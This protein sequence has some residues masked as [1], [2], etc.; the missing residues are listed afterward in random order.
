[1]K[2]VAGLIG[3]HRWIP[4]LVWT[5][6]IIGLSSIPDLDIGSRRFPGCD[7]VAHFIEYSVLGIT[8]RYW[9]GRTKK[10]LVPGGLCFAALDELHQRYVPGREAS[11]WDFLADASGLIFG[12]LISRRF[13]RKGDD[14]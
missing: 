6:A 7:K 2:R 4:T 11:L 14:G 9:S 3:T 13:F 10:H 12:F 1:M 8:L 5:A